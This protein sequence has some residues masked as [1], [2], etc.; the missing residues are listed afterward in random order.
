MNNNTSKFNFLQISSDNN[1]ATTERLQLFHNVSRKNK[2]PPKKI[3]MANPID[4]KQ[5]EK[6]LNT[7]LYGK[8]SHELIPNIIRSINPEKLV[9]LLTNLNSKVE[10]MSFEDYY[11]DEIKENKQF[12][13]SVELYLNELKFQ[14]EYIVSTTKNVQLGLV[15]NPLQGKKTMN[16]ENNQNNPHELTQEEYVKYKKKQEEIDFSVNMKKIESMKEFQN[17]LL[18]RKQASEKIAEEN[19]KIWAQKVKDAQ[20]RAEELK[21]HA[22]EAEEKTKI[23]R[24]EQKE[25]E[26]KQM[27]AHK[28][29]VDEKLLEL[30]L[31]RQARIEKEKA[32]EAQ[33]DKEKAEKEVERRK[34]V[35]EAWNKKL[36]TIRSK[37]LELSKEK[38]KEKEKL[39][40]QEKEEK[41]TLF[42]INKAKQEWVKARIEAFSKARKEHEAKKK[43]IQEEWQAK[44]AEQARKYAEQQE[45]ENNN[46]KEKA[47]QDFIKRQQE[48]KKAWEI[49][50]EAKERA[51]ETKKEEERQKQKEK[52]NQ[53]NLAKINAE[54]L[55]EQEEVSSRISYEE[56]EEKLKEYREWLIQKREQSTEKLQQKMRE[57]KRMGNIIMN[58]NS[59]EKNHVRNNN[60]SQ[61]ETTN[62][63]QGMTS[64]ELTK[65]LVVFN[66]DFYRTHYHDVK[67]L[68]ISEC[69]KHYLTKGKKEGRIISKKHAQY[70]T[71]VLDFD[72]IFYKNFHNDLHNLSLR[73]VCSHFISH[74]KEERRKYKKEYLQD[75][76]LSITSNFIEHRSA[77][78]DLDTCIHDA[79]DFVEEHDYDDTPK[80][81]IIFPYYEKKNHT[82]N[83]T[84]LA[85]F[86]KYAMNKSLWRNLNITLLLMINGH[87][88]EVEIPIRDDIIVW[89]RDYKGDRD[90]GSYKV[91]IE[92]MEKLHNK[93]FY[94]VYN[95]LFIMNSSA[96]GP[97]WPS[98]KN[99]HWLDPFL[100]KLHKENSIVCSPVINFLKARD[101]GGPGPRC[102]TYCSL[103]KI[104]QQ[105]YDLLLNTKISKV[106][107]NTLN[108]EFKNEKKMKC[109]FDIHSS[110][111]DVI[112]YGEYGFT[113]VFLENG[114]NI[115]SLIYDDVDYYDNKKW[116]MY[117]DRADRIDEYKIDYFYKA[118]FI[119]NN[120]SV[121]SSFKDSLP[122]LYDITIGTI[123]ETMLWVDFVKESNMD[124]P[125][126]YETSSL[127][128]TGEFNIGVVDAESHKMGTKL[129]MGSWNTQEENYKLFGESEEVVIFPK[130]QEPPRDVCIYTHTDEDNKIKDYVVQGIKT[131]IILG[132]DV[133]F[134]SSCSNIT[135]IDLPFPIQYYVFEPTVTDE[136]KHTHM[137][138]HCLQT[139]DFTRYDHILMLNNTMIFPVHGF[140]NMKKQIDFMR[141]R[142][143]FWSGYNTNGFVCGNNTCFE[144]ST[145]C[146]DKL[147]SFFNNQ[148][149]TVTD[150]SKLPGII[151]LNMVQALIKHGF[152]Y[153]SV[154][155]YP[156]G[157]PLR[158]CLQ[159]NM[160]FSIKLQSVQKYL[161]KSKNEIKNPVLRFLMRFL[162]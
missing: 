110:I 100:N 98:G 123:Y 137:L 34:Q 74:G 133:M 18:I 145:K 122:V 83:Q 61:A 89:K 111:S 60:T 55:A 49:R 40:N 155:N 42:E 113:R 78:S 77:I 8:R 115:S 119:K 101:A 57:A 104:T 17:Q 73:E 147:I 12:Y 22:I 158:A 67:E 126:Q 75:D 30:R 112:L 20:Q 153:N 120:W 27:D 127:E 131:L 76:Q 56:K 136:Y 53:E 108:H 2:G 33:Q 135:N 91:G 90:I 149:R 150:K 50:R 152:S 114:Y 48:A 106:C 32:Q 102:Q 85:Y 66:F 43:A 95:Y 151:E 94:D 79:F 80:V 141:T 38:E 47:I 116:G 96:T 117:S 5:T 6:N 107:P 31:A 52:E 154:I 46:L 140:Q 63:F 88:C 41:E 161:R 7:A 87:E 81:C 19:A 44:K 58:Q 86:L 93:S 70:I 45:T 148:Q 156:N 69:L 109:V 59:S 118:V 82:K 97:F 10:F 23:A 65:L 11:Q 121:D 64:A 157:I 134:C 105:T 9:S 72:I 103:I 51:I 62:N 4:L 24:Q 28:K 37:I 125:L 130:Y 16:Y 124:I 144:I 29:A 128:P 92:Y 84:N 36:Q 146:R 159:N 99:T 71:G 14:Q 162:L 132:Y 39:I 1:P 142:G 21:Q 35:E 68:S 54:K 143:D 129:L 25:V 3:D 160:C 26:K 139:F 13:N 15:D 138:F